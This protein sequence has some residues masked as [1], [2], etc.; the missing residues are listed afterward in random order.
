MK[1]TN[2]LGDIA[3]AVFL[4]LAGLAAFGLAFPF[5]DILSGIAALAGG[6][7]KLIGK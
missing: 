3:L 5:M 2:N 4:I 1:L 6:V 7:L